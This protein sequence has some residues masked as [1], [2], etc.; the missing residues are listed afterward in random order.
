MSPNK[1]QLLLGLPWW[2]NGWE[3]T[4]QCR[5][6]GLDPWSRKIPHAIGQLSPQ[7]TTIEPT[8]LK[9]VLCNQRSPCKEKPKNR[10]WRVATAPC[11]HRKPESSNKDPAKP[12]SFL[13]KPFGEEKKITTTLDLTLQKCFFLSLLNFREQDFHPLHCSRQIL[14]IILVSLLPTP[15]TLLSEL[16]DT[17]KAWTLCQYFEYLLHQNQII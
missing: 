2:S 7:A 15:D 13:K 6:H 9:P 8:C 16:K 5:G 1:L 4:G 17:T 11:N 3:S 14:G 12:N 10:N